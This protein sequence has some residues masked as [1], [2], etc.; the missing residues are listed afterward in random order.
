MAPS[1]ASEDL[2]TYRRI[3]YWALV[4]FS[5]GIGLVGRHLAL[6]PANGTRQYATPGWTWALPGAI[7]L[8]GFAVLLVVN[9]RGRVSTT[10][11]DSKSE[12]KVRGVLGW[13]LAP[14]LPLWGWVVSATLAG[15][16]GLWHLLIPC[17][18]VALAGIAYFYDRTHRQLPA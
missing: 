2:A 11:R 8:Y 4:L 16:H 9:R 10:R 15:S 7:G 18:A 3:E 6:L 5:A 13:L 17:A 14:M 1:A 12:V